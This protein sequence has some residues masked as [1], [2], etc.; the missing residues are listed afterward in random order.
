V[1]INSL[2]RGHSGVR[3]KFI[4]ALRLLLEKNI[5]PIV[6]LRGSISAS[7]DLSPLSYVGGTL[8]GNPSIDVFSTPPEK[9]GGDRRIVSCV[10]AFK[11]HG[12]E[13]VAFE[14]KE[15]LGLVNGT[16][17]STAVGSLAVKSTVDLMMLT[18]ITTAMGTEAMLGTQGT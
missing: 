18:L 15:H 14:A 5:I 16:A 6:P 3:W 8:L 1:R 4:D 12:L 2:I 7:G 13:H 17:F 9:D 11:E 10:K